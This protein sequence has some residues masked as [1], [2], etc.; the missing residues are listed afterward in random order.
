VIFLAV[1][2]DRTSNDPPVKRLN[3]AAMEASLDQL[4]DRSLY[5]A[6]A[7]ESTGQYAQSTKE[8][9]CL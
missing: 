5:L 2:L 1:Y 8:Q 3:Q 6:A 7:D 4:S 9:R